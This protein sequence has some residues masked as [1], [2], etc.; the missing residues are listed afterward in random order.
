MQTGWKLGVLLA[1][2]CA[3]LAGSAHSEETWKALLEQQLVAEEKCQLNYL[4]DVSEAEGTGVKARAHCED[5]RSFDVHMAPGKSKFEISA[6][7][8]TYC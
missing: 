8:P 6:C 7:K 4:T 5:K 3:G 2:L 1:L